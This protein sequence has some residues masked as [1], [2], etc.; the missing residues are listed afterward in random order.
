[1]HIYYPARQQ[2]VD[3]ARDDGQNAL[4]AAIKEVEAMAT[5]DVSQVMTPIKKLLQ[6]VYRAD[7]AWQVQ[8]MLTG[9]IRLKPFVV[10]AMACA[11]TDVQRFMVD[12]ATQR[13]I[14]RNVPGDVLSG[15]TTAIV[16]IAGHAPR[17]PEI[18]GAVVPDSLP[19]DFARLVAAYVHKAR[20]M[21]PTTYLTVKQ[22][23]LEPFEFFNAA[24]PLRD[25]RV[26][27]NGAGQW[28]VTAR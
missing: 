3:K 9:K 23:Q 13:P 18:T 15:T 4:A 19:V 12:V 21:F 10:A 25:Y 6:L 28:V 7:R 1:V 5:S 16:P 2:A 11:H 17:P 27:Q 20:I 8:A 26:T 14:W 24:A 22:I